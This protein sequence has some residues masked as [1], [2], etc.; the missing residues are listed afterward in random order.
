M[1]YQPI[2]NIQDGRLLGVEALIRWN[3]PEL[4]LILP[5]RFIPLA[6]EMRLISR[7]DDWALEELCTQLDRWRGD[8]IRMVGSFSLS[9]CRLW[10]PDVARHVADTVESHGI[11]PSNVVIEI[12]ESTAMADPDLTTR[13]LADLHSR[14]LRV[15]IDDFGTAYS[16]LSRLNDLEVDVLKI[17]APFVQG[18]PESAKAAKMLADIVGLARAVGIEPIGEGIESVLQGQYLIERGCTMGQGFL[19]SPPVPAEAIPRLVPSAA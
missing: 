8:G 4:G 18:A 16:S 17:A 12:T 1:H 5:D 2:V 19:F 14:G 10:E 6:E 13:V 15:A 11:A 9:L 3:D 7:I